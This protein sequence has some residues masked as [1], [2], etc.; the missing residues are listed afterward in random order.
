MRTYGYVPEYHH[1]G[2]YACCEVLEQSVAATGSCDS[3]VLRGYL[4]ANSFATVMG[5]LRFQDNGLPSATMQLSQIVQ[6]KVRIVYPEV[7]K[8]GE[9]V[10]HA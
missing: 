1:A 10:L 4:L 6:G 5:D 2:G 7:A 9:P 3:E 8:T